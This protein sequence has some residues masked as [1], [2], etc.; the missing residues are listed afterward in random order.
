MQTEC[1]HFALPFHLLAS[2]WWV[3][4][5]I[6]RNAFHCEQQNRVSSL[7]KN[8]VPDLY[9][10]S[11]ISCTTITLYWHVP[12]RLQNNAKECGWEKSQKNYYKILCCF[13]LIIMKQVDFIWFVTNILVWNFFSKRKKIVRPCQIINI[14]A[15]FERICNIIMFNDVRVPLKFS[16]LLL[17]LSFAL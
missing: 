14:I 17:T 5:L 11:R 16:F 2:I 12:I 4:N 7:W 1:S 3:L 6:T 10:N 9:C 15:L 8:L 13:V